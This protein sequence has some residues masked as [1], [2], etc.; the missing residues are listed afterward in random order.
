MSGLHLQ[1]D[2]GE[3]PSQAGR[4]PNGLRADVVNEPA[5]IAKRL[6]VTR[7]LVENRTRA[8]R[9]LAI[10]NADGIGAEETAV[11]APRSLF[12]AATEHTNRSVQCSLID[13]PP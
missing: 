5:A 8:A 13:R 2:H 10:K 11:A 3:T 6:A 4:R 7:G 12:E 9:G 1:P